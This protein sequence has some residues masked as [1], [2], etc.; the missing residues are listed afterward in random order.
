MSES[1][2][3]VL[4]KFLSNYKIKSKGNTNFNFTV[5]DIEEKLSYSTYKKYK[6]E[7]IDIPKARHRTGN[8]NRVI[9]EI[10]KKDIEELTETVSNI[11]KVKLVNTGFFWYP[12]L[13]YCGWHTNSDNEGRRIYYIFSQEKNKSFLRNIQNDQIVTKY[14]NLGWTK[15]DFT[16]SSDKT[17]LNWHCVGSYTN[18]ISIGFKSL[19]STKTIVTLF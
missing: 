7:Y 3:E 16:V 19:E 10:S 6:D 2:L 9:L 5:S 4:D 18:R 1:E 12:P 14:D 13:S 15:N 11:N 8:D 17:N